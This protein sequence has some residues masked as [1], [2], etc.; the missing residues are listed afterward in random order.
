MLKHLSVKNYALIDAL[1]LDFTNGLT[2]LT[3][4]TGAGKSI[5]LGA[6]ALVL[7]KRADHSSL[8]DPDAKCIVEATFQ[9]HKAGFKNFFEKYDLDLEEESI[10]RREVKP[11]GKSRAFINDTP[12][13]LNVLNELG[14][15][16][17]DIHSQHDTLLLNNSA[18]QLQLLD[19]F[20][21]NALQ[22]GAYARAFDSWK[23]AKLNI[24]SFEQSMQIESF[25][26]DYH[27]FLFD[28]L[29]EANL[30]RGEQENLEAELKILESA[31]DIRELLA[32]ARQSFEGT[33]G[34]GI[35]N[36]IQDLSSMLKRLGSFGD[37]FNALSERLESARLEL[38]DIQSEIDSEADKID[39]DPNRLRM[40][41]ERLS[42]I[43]RLQKKHGVLD[44]DELIQKREQIA[45]LLDR[46]A[47]HDD[48]L[49]ELQ[50]EVEKCRT[51]LETKADELSQSRKKAVP[52]VE[53]GIVGLLADLN[54][55]S[56]RFNVELKS[57]EFQSSGSDDIAFRFSA[58]PGQTPQ[59]LSKVASGGELSR[60]MLAVKAT[61][62][63][64]NELPT[65]IFDEID[66]GVSGETAGKIGSILH[67]MARG[68]QVV[69]IT[70][71]PQIASR[72]DAHLKVYKEV[73]GELTRTDIVRLHE[74]ARLTELARMLSGEQ[75]TDAAI[76]NARTLL[77]N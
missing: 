50:E 12:V 41:D 60:V 19:S 24:K 74:D 21:N 22:L 13:T 32:S 39:V 64:K 17:V 52:I 66:S 26:Q 16:L 11:G 7:G 23:Q 15:R 75:I 59:S 34:G 20:A 54:M 28:E 76:A 5:I 29:E 8:R 9:I 44:E 61:M 71:L 27:Q 35:A 36:S 67:Q 37:Q 46:Y 77:Q 69:A 45:E 68:M 33:E 63:E 53:R 57:S 2:V 4:E 56:A 72:G 73:E 31:G 62:A 10:L 43:I 6:L 38:D 30:Q 14:I 48:R 18:F 49:K 42:M 40:V 25:D 1:E 58:N 51:Q 3:G 47:H 70:H 65:I 55:P